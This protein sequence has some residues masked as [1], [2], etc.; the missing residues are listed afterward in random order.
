MTER[1]CGPDPGTP[2]A[3]QAAEWRS[4]ARAWSEYIE[5]WWQEAQAS[6]PEA[7]H[8]FFRTLID[9][10]KAYFEIIDGVLEATRKPRLG[11]DGPDTLQPA[12]R[13]A[14]ARCAGAPPALWRD[15]LEAWSRALGTLS[16]GLLPAGRGEDA[17]VGA[18]LQ[19]LEDAAR[20]L[21]AALGS[22]TPAWEREHQTGAEA[23]RRYQAALTEYTELYR[24]LGAD[25]LAR[26]RARADEMARRG[27]GV[28]EPR[29]LYDLW[30]DCGEAAY[31]DMVA[32][33]RYARAYGE[34][35]N[36]LLALRRQGQRVS[37]RLARLLDLPTRAEQDALHAQVLALRRAL[38][39][40]ER[41]GAGPGG[42]GARARRPRGE[43]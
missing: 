13:A 41:E 14:W 6:T 17:R 9:Q 32:S 39:R 36:S 30:V 24:E 29:A 12:L 3:E 34:L 20:T 35:V 15:P 7:T 10:G 23:W 26:L 37:E 43:R 2:G 31:E 25:A 11:G 42:G 1:A 40:L 18:A 19:A 33:E 21:W 22:G 8:P 16:H 28:E 5:R 38:R 4:S 27:E